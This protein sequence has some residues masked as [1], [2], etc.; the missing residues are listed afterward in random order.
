MKRLIDFLSP[1]G[2]LVILGSQAASMAGKNLPGQERYYLIGGAF[3]IAL[4]LVLRFE[5]IVRFVGRRQLRYG[6]NAF[7]FVAGLLVI[8]VALNWLAF[9]NPKRWDLTKN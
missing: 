2:L 4:H 3:L 5:E 7:L 8:L 9:R 6:G 1:L